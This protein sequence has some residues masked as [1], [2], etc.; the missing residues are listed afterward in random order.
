MY[1]LA[2]IVPHANVQLG[3]LADGRTSSE[4]TRYTPCPPPGL[5]I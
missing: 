2:G 5:S 1:S 4:Y 3:D